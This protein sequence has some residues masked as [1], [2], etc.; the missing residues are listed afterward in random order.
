MFYAKIYSIQIPRTIGRTRLL[1][2]NLGSNCGYET[3]IRFTLNFVPIYAVL[4]HVL[5]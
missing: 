2:R 4:V 3:Y 1:R 5:R